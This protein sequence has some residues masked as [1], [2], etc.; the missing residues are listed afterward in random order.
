M[1]FFIS[2]CSGP[3]EAIEGLFDDLNHTVLSSEEAVEE[4]LCCL[5]KNV[6]TINRRYGTRYKLSRFEKQQEACLHCDEVDGGCWIS[7][8]P[9]KFM[10]G[11]PVVREVMDIGMKRVS[12]GF[13]A[14][15]GKEVER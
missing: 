15:C 9:I 12:A 5:E 2:V 4:F 10:A 13:A 8:R 1:K 11:A 7:W 6:E 3:D 14:K